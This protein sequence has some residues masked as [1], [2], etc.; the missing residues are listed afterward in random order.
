MKETR[1]SDTVLCAGRLYCDLVFTGVPNLPVMGT[2]TFAEDLSLHAGGGAFITAAAFSALGRKASLLA[3]LPAAPFDSIVR[4]EIENSGVGINYC[5]AAARGAAPQLT[6]AITGKDDRAFLSNKSGEAMPDIDL[7][8]GSFRHLH[9]GELRSLVEYPSLI[10]KARKADMTISLDCAWDAELLAQG[11]K[12]SSLL[13]K[14]DV[15]LPNDSEYSLLK[16]SGLVEG[17]SSLTVVKCGREGARSLQQGKW[18]TSPAFPATVVDSTGA[19]DA[20]NGGFLTSWLSG[21]P[22][23]DCLLDGNRCGHISVGQAGGTGG[24]AGLRSELQYQSKLA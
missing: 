14:V 3:T 11:S 4:T 2:E 7:T 9:I 5:K 10:E 18:T 6:V 13:A 8:K 12:L 17:A 24:L 23:S 20:F 16:Q 1:S 21:K 22:V 15:F 19:G